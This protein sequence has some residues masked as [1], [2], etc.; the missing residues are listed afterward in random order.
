LNFKQ[1]KKRF[2]V[3]PKICFGKSLL[4]FQKWMIQVWPPLLLKLAL[5]FLEAIPSLYFL[6]LVALLSKQFQI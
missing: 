4:T 5:R 2:L 3:L 1:L 6:I